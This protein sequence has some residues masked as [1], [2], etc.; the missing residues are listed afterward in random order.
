MLEQVLLA[1][2][3]ACGELTLGQIYP[4][5]LQ[6]VEKSAPEQGKASRGRSDREELL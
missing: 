2:T 3:A 1:G 6:P 4:K 5:G